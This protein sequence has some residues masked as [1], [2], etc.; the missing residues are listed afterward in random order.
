[1]L[2]SDK[3]NYIIITIPKTGTRSISNFLFDNEDSIIKNRIYSNSSIFEFERSST[4]LEIKNRVGDELYKKYIKI[5][6]IRNPYSKL[7]SSYFFYKNGTPT[8]NNTFQRFLRSSLIR[9]FS[10]IKINLK[11]LSTKLLPFHVWA[12][13]YPYNSNLKYLTNEQGNLIVDY[14]GTSED[15][16]ND[17]FAIME[18]IGVKFEVKELPQINKSSHKNVESY[19]NNRF[20]KTLIDLKI[21]KDLRFYFKIR[22]TH[23]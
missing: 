20:F 8:P 9:K 7:V 3:Y 14:V 22:R 13:L 12:L 23:S 19:F 5:A 15:L 4:A 16:E 6:F 1:M 11:I 17:F 18:K 10:L 21:R 2:V